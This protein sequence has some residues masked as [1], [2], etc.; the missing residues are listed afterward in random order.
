MWENF[1]V[2]WWCFSIKYFVPFALWFLLSYSL[3][4]DLERRYGNYH[5]FWQ[6]MG[7]V[8]PILGL[9]AFLISFIVCTEKDPFTPDLE[10]AFTSDEDETNPKEV[11]MA[12]VEGNPVDA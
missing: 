2:I 3:S 10:C 4:I 1:F 8:Y 7:L 6:W 5:V 9:L 12:A 11:E